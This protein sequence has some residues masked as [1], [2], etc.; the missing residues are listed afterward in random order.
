MEVIEMNEHLLAV[1]EESIRSKAYELWQSRGGGFGDPCFDWYQAKE[2]L[3][4]QKRSQLETL[5]EPVKEQ[6]RQAVNWYKAVTQVPEQVS[7]LQKET[8]ISMVD[9]IAD[10]QNETISAIQTTSEKALKFQETVTMNSIELQS[11]FTRMSI[12]LQKQVWQQ[13]FQLLKKWW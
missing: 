4:E 2:M 1:D 6:T 5:V 11:Q 12:E 8:A 3:L 10:K 13:Y 7:E 9:A